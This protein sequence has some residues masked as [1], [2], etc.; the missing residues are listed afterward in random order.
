MSISGGFGGLGGR[1]DENV[2]AWL[3]CLS[4]VGSTAEVA[5]PV[6]GSGV[7]SLLAKASMLLPLAW[8]WA[9]CSRHLLS[10]LIS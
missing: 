1:N 4:N 10:T 6:S 5:P 7:S 2:G 8:S 9:R 3:L